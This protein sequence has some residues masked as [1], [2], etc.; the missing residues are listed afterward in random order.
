MSWRPENTNLICGT[1][2]WWFSPYAGD[3]FGDCRRYPPNIRNEHGDTE[4]PKTHAG[5]DWCGEYVEGQPPIQETE[6]CD[7]AHEAE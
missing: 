2:R 6:E 4:Y 1:C 5:E 7:T 3:D